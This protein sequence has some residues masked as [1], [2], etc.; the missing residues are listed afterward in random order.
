MNRVCHQLSTCPTLRNF[1][2]SLLITSLLLL[3]PL[4]FTMPGRRK[5]THAEK[6]ESLKRRINAIEKEYDVTELQKYARHLVKKAE[7][8]PR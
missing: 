1:G 3:E 2:A 5:L 7:K 8:Q 6:V 4:T